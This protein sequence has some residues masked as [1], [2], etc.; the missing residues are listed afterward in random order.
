MLLYSFGKVVLRLLL[1]KQESLRRQDTF[2]QQILLTLAFIKTGR[3][4]QCNSPFE[5]ECP[6]QQDFH[7]HSD[8]LILFF[9]L[10]LH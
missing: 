10:H 9:C 4:G 1:F 8:Y 2:S 5:S 3:S 6:F 7:D